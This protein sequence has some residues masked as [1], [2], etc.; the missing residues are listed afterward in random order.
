MDDASKA[1]IDGLIRRVA[2]L[3]AE[4][5][6]RDALLNE[7]EQ[8]KNEYLQNVAHQLTAPIN[9]IK[10]NIESLSDEA[11]AIKRKQV[12]LRSIYSQ[13]NILVHLI[14]N[15][16][17]MSH[18]EADHELEGFREQPASVD[19]FRLCINLC[20]DF[21][22]MGEYRSLKIITDDKSFERFKPPT[23]HV[24]KNLVAQVIYNL[25]ENAVKYSDKGST[26][27]IS[28]DLFPSF[29]KLN[30]ENQWIPIG[31]EEIG[32]VF[33]RGIRGEN[34]VAL[35]PSGTGIGL[36]IAQRIMQI[37]KGRIELKV[38]GRKTVFSVILPAK[39]Q[40]P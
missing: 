27:T 31:P 32:R 14:K 19:L 10:M 28:V 37:H 40:K 38:N 29:V 3:E 23:V 15:F 7:V 8:R 21:Q 11:I 30:I 24:I 33:N 16:S 4:I 9:A 35:H 17:L 2:E 6:R 36:F 12:L 20:N 34:A 39:T 1:E 5:L 13:G 26:I 22:P 18:L 25:L